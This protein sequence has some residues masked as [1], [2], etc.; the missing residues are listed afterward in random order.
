MPRRFRNTK[1]ARWHSRA[2][3]AAE[4]LVHPPA[5]AA[6]TR[7]ILHATAAAGRVQRRVRRRSARL[8]EEPLEPRLRAGPL[9]QVVLD[10]RGPAEFA[11]RA[12]PGPPSSLGGRR[13]RPTDPPT[14]CRHGDSPNSPVRRPRSIVWSRVASEHL[15]C[16]AVE[17]LSRRTT[18]FTCRT[19]CKERDVAENRNAGP[20]KCKGWFARGPSARPVL[21]VLSKA[22]EGA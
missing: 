18:P 13:P 6:M 10:G 2:G 4:L 19:G 9:R 21:A 17:L 20:V 11:G 1:H 8:L 12:R 15:R 7:R 14:A 16:T 22:S 5:A 3:R